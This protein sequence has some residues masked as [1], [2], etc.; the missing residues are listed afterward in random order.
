MINPQDIGLPDIPPSSPR[1]TVNHGRRLRRKRR[2]P[3]FRPRAAG[4]ICEI[5]N[6]DRVPLF[7]AECSPPPLTENALLKSNQIAKGYTGMV[8]ARVIGFIG[9]LLSSRLAS[10]RQASSTSRRFLAVEWRARLLLMS[11]HKRNG[12]GAVDF[13]AKLKEYAKDRCHTCD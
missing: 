12:K 3:L 7:S 13:S 4:S 11:A 5:N 1:R 9:N 8:R 2:P 10:N 6:V